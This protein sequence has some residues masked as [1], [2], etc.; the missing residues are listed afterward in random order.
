MVLFLMFSCVI[1]IE[2]V[3]TVGVT[4]ME[5]LYSDLFARYNPEVRPSLNSSQTTEVTVQMSLAHIMDLDIKQQVLHLIGF[6]SLRWTDQKLTWTPGMYG[7]IDHLFV[8]QNQVWKPDIAVINSVSDKVYVGDTEVLVVV[9][10]NGTVTWEPVINMQVTCQVNILKYPF[11]ESIC[12]LELTSWMYSEDSV[13]LRITKTPLRMVM[14]EHSQ[15]RVKFH[16]AEIFKINHHGAF[17]TRLNFLFKLSRR[18]SYLV[19]ILVLPVTLLAILCVVS[20]MLSPEVPEKTSLAITILLAYTVYLDI[21]DK[22]L[23]EISVQISHFVKYL[24]VL[25][26]LS[27]FCVTGNA[28]VFVV[29][30]RGKARELDT[31]TQEVSSVTH[32]SDDS[33]AKPSPNQSGFHSADVNM[34]ECKGRRLQ[35]RHKTK[36]EKMNFIFLV[37]NSVLLAL[38]ISGYFFSVL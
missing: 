7:G 30:K 25:L 32:F 9:T 37:L 14:A 21:V 4:E 12:G 24:T 15:Y 29:H 13:P 1:F 28:I 35:W 26:F 22:E 6:V 36:A 11:D 2:G 3:N 10:S 38:A 20:F 18:A 17:Y 33:I 27:F 19:L 16:N 34:S 31:L 23:P 5:R 8:R